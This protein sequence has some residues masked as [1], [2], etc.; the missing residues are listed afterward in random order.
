MQYAIPRASMEVAQRQIHVIARIQAIQ[1]ARATYHIIATNN[2]VKVQ[3]ERA[4]VA[5]ALLFDA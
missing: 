1:G 4:L 2:A 5:L 3:G